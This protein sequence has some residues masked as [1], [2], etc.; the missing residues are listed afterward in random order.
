M[1]NSFFKEV[2]IELLSEMAQT[3]SKNNQI[4]FITAAGIFEGT[5][6]YEMRELIKK[7][8]DK[9]KEEFKDQ[10]TV[11]LREVFHRENVTFH[12]GSKRDTFET[13]PMVHLFT[14]QIIGAYVIK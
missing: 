12:P 6:T 14:D 13:I 2:F 8:I 3:E 1:A 10:P 5:L 11:H 4:A 7:A 9:A